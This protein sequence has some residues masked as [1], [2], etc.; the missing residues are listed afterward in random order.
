MNINTS[1]ISFKSENESFKVNQASEN[2]KI[3]VEKPFDNTAPIAT[4]QS[5]NKDGANSDDNRSTGDNQLDINIQLLKQILK[6]LYNEDFDFVYA[7]YN[8]AQEIVDRKNAGIN[9]RFTNIDDVNWKIKYERSDLLIEH[10][11]SS[12]EAKGIINTSD[13]KKIEF[14]LQMNMEYNN[15]Q[16][17]KN[18]IEISK[19]RKDPL[20]INFDGSSELLDSGTFNFDLEANGVL[21]SIPFLKSGKGLLVID[22]NND[23]VVNNG[24][25][26]V[27]GASG[28]AF[29]E[30]KSY[31]DDNNNW[32]DEKDNVYNKLKVWEVNQNGYNKL[33][34]LKQRGVGAIY[35]GNIATNFYER[36]NSNEPIG[37]I[38]KSG[39]FVNNE[40]KVLPLHQ[41]DFLL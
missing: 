9:S 27:G 16:L 7:D 23:K 41:L 22:T 29:E 28:N 14:S 34:S 25:E 4:R 35:L 39:I 6:E 38:K 10:Q 3:F 24:L 30:L 19:Q 1:E 11:Q 8:K 5:H 36:N 12:Y 2:I 40:H 31:D 21:S 18:A 17:S 15:V 33:S 26:L 32:I 13:G 20:I 37:E